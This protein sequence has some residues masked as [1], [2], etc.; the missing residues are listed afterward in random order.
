MRIFGLFL[1]FLGA[2]IVLSLLGIL[3]MSVGKFF[4]WVFAI[5]FAYTGLSAI[6]KRGF[7]YG[8][9]SLVLS[10]ILVTM[11]L[12]YYSLGFWETIAIIVGVGLIELG[13]LA[14]G[15]GKKRWIKWLGGGPFFG[16][17][18]RKTVEENM[19]NIKK[20]NVTVEGESAILRVKN[21]SDKLYKVIYTGNPHIYFDRQE[22]SGNLVMKLEGI[23]FISK[24]DVNL[25]LNEEIE[26]SLDVSMDVSSITMDLE[27]LKISSLFLEGDVT[28][29]KIRF[30]KYNSTIVI[31]SDVANIEL[32]IPSDVGVKA[33][34]SD[35]V[36]WKEMKGFENREGVYYSKNWDTANFKVDLKIESD[37]SR[38]KIKI[39]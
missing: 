32:E 22:D 25:L 38:I 17:G 31:G 9:V 37:V 33:V 29:L 10:A 15:F 20:L 18:S 28:D 13:L 12:G 35:S 1:I 24:S 16:G 36:S 23:P 11:G 30:P 39:K 2:V 34:V 6:F 19:D 4:A 5:V 26:I 21:C 3:E 8:L 7:P 14:M 27:K